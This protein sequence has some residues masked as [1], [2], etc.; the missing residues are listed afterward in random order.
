MSSVRLSLSWLWCCS[1]HCGLV[2]KRFSDTFKFSS[3]DLRVDVYSEVFSSEAFGQDGFQGVLDF[4]FFLV[5]KEPRLS[6]TK[7]GECLER[8]SP[9]WRTLESTT[10]GRS[11]GLRRK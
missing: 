11:L 7:I 9:L 2:Q 3:L 4:T 8:L 6:L 1:V 5:G 10:K